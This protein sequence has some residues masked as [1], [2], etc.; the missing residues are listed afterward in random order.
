MRNL[1]RFGIAIGDWW[2]SSQRQIAVEELGELG[3]MLL[4]LGAEGV[5]VVLRVRL[6]LEDDER[7]LDAGGTQLAVDA[8]GVAQEEIA[9]ARSE[10]GRRKALKV[11]IDRREL[12]VAEIVTSGVELRGI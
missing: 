5:G 7:R 1:T 4:G 3:E 11:A 6:A 8:H 10:G 12:W 2:Y 9:R